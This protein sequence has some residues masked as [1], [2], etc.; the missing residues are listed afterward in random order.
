MDICGPGG[1]CC[2]TV[3][4]VGSCV[5]SA[6]ISGAN[7][8]CVDRDDCYHIEIK[9]ITNIALGYRELL[10]LECMNNNF[11]QKTNS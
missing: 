10:E 5:N 2:K 8:A 6:T 11:G 3:S 7:A 1:K 4:G 9:A